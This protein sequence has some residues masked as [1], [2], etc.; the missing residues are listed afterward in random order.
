MEAVSASEHPASSRKTTADLRSPWNTKRRLRISDISGLLSSF[1][2]D[3]WKPSRV[4]GWPRVLRRMVL[5]MAKVS[6][7]ATL[8]EHLAEAPFQ[9]AEE[10][11]E[12]MMDWN[13]E[14][15]RRLALD[16]GYQTLIDIAPE[17]GEHVG[18]ALACVESERRGLP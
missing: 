4:H 11:C 5:V 1:A 6:V 8:P 15:L 2:H 16:D 12:L 13:P 18:H 9:H 7:V 17:H 3:A 10:G 14:L